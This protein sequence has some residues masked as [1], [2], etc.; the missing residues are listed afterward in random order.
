MSEKRPFILLFILIILVGY[1]ITIP[2]AAPLQST[3]KLCAARA[4]GAGT[5]IQTHHLIGDNKDAFVGL[6][7]CEGIPQGREMQPHMVTDDPPLSSLLKDRCRGVFMPVQTA[8][9]IPNQWVDVWQKPADK[10]PK[11]LARRV[12]I[13]KAES[14][15]YW[16]ELPS[17]QVKRILGHVENTSLFF[18]LTHNR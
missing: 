14:N 12:R 10:S 17:R 11:I 16:I 2:S 1:S 18:T 6:Y 15:G 9:F 5:Y 13:L 3:N 8:V 7:A 4:I